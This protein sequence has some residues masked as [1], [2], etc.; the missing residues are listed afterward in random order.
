MGHLMHFFTK[1]TKYLVSIQYAQGAVL[2]LGDGGEL[3]VPSSLVF[4]AWGEVSEQ[5]QQRVRHGRCL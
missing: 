3:S 2:E 4:G 5:V 1:F